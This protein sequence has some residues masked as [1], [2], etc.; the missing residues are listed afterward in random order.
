MSS[1][2]RILHAGLAAAAAFGALAGCGPPDQPGEIVAAASVTPTIPPFD[3]DGDLFVD[4]TAA[5]GIDFVHHL[6][7][8]RMDNVL[9]SIGSGA[10]WI[11]FD[12][13]GWLDLYLVDSAWRQGVSRGR[14]PATPATNRLYRNLGDGR[15]EDVTERAGVGDPGFGFSAAVADFD[16]DGDDDLYVCNQGPN[17]LYRNRGDGRFEDATAAAGVGDDSCSVAAVFFDADGDGRLDLYVANYLRFDPDYQAHYSPDAFPG[18]LAYAAE[19]DR[20]YRNRGDGR[21]EDATAGSGLD[22]APGRSMG[23]TAAD[24]AGDGRTGLFLA[25]D[26]T[27][28]FLFRNRGGGRFE[29][30]GLVAGVAYGV[31][32]EATG[33]MAGSLGDYDGDGLP[34]LSV[35]DTSYGSLYR[36]QGGGAFQDQVVRAGVA[37]ASA[38]RVSWGGGLFDYDNDGDL[39]LYLANGDLHHPTGRADLLLENTGDGRFTDASPRAGAC[40]RAELLSRG[41][42]IGDYDNDGDL[43][44][45]VTHIGDRPLLLQNQAAAGNHW[46]GVS[47]AATQGNRAG[48][49]A[50][51]ELQAGGRRWIQQ[52]Q[53]RCGYLTQGDPRLHFGLGAIDAVDRLTVRWPDG[54]SESFTGLETGRY[55]LLVQGDGVR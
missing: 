14:P 26:A 46:I 45:L 41:G 19:A 6:G 10:S 38:Q 39:D 34:D 50:T 9:E 24:L 25:N 31:H 49:G 36:N 12:G 48:W 11:D 23:V 40:F 15:F 54:S 21:F 37:A 32:G 53:P 18:P 33:A 44:L 13:D 51:V 29:E 28:N 5:A 7:D 20:L 35:T 30:D 55:Q 52:H 42:L 43:D 3:P 22:V 1:G 8:G 17:R 2:P 4:R 27:A 16:D 47:L